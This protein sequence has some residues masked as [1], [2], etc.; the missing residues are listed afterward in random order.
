MAKQIIGGIIGF[1]LGSLGIPGFGPALGWSVGTLIGSSLDAPSMDVPKLKDLRLSGSSYGVGIPLV[2]GTARVGLNLVWVGEL[3]ERKDGAFKNGL[4]QKGAKDGFSIDLAGIVCQGLRGASVKRVKADDKVIWKPGGGDHNKIDPAITP[5]TEDQ[6][7]PAMLGDWGAIGGRGMTRH[8]GLV[9]IAIEDLDITET[10]RIP[11]LTVVVEGAPATVGDICADIFG[12]VGLDEED[13]DVSAATDAVTGFVVTQPA[14]ASEVLADLLEKYEYDLS[15][16]DGVL[17]LVKRG[18]S[19]V[20]TIDA[21]DL[22]ASAGIPGGDGRALLTSSRAKETDLPRRVALTYTSANPF[23]NYDQVTQT[24]VRLG[25]ASDN[26]VAL[27]TRLVLH[28]TEARQIAERFKNRAWIERWTF[29]F[30]LP[31]EYLFLA[32]ADCV[33]LPVGGSLRRV[34]ITRI[35]TGLIGEM[36]F[37]AVLDDAAVQAQGTP[38]SPPAAPTNPDLLPTLAT[39]FD[40]WSGVEIVPTDGLAPG[41][42]AVGAPQAGSAPWPGAEVFYSLDGGVSYVFAGRLASGGVFGETE[43]ALGDGAD[44]DDWDETNEVAVQL[45]DGVGAALEEASDEQVLARYTNIALLGEEVLGFTGALDNTGRSYTLSRLQRGL[46]GEPT[47]HASGD[48]FVLLSEGGWDRFSVPASL[49][50]QT[51]KVKVVTAGK[52]LAGVTAIDV[53]IPVP[54][55]P[56]ASPEEVQDVIDTLEGHRLSDPIDHVDGSAPLSLLAQDGAAD[57]QVLAWSESLGEWIAAHAPGR[58][59]T[60]FAQTAE[61]QIANTTS[62]L[63]LFG[64]GQGSREIPADTLEVGMVIRVVLKGVYATAANADAADLE[65]KLGSTV[66]ASAGAMDLESVA[67]GWGP[68]QPSWELQAELTV[69]AQ[70]ASGAVRT[71]GF[72]R[73]LDDFNTTIQ[74]IPVRSDPVT[75]DTT[76]DLIVDAVWDWA[77]ASTNYDIRSKTGYVELLGV[78]GVTAGVGG[79]GGDPGPTGPEGPAGAPGSQIYHDTGA[80]SG[81]LGI[82]GDYYLDTETNELYARESGLWSVIAELG[83]GGG[84]AGAKTALIEELGLTPGAPNSTVYVTHLP[85]SPLDGTTSVTWTFLRAGLFVESAPSGGAAGFEVYLNGVSILSA[86]LSIADGQHQATPATHF[87]VPEGHSGDVLAWRFNAIHGADGFNPTLYL[88]GDY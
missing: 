28:D 38:G 42:Y 52:P 1:G 47:G 57:G 82:D 43:D 66:V 48:R 19:V 30:S 11:N 44:L 50:G 76:T 5:G 2:W 60:I 41:F 7:I 67:G 86:P 15:E 22:G 32:P 63:T 12:M 84:G 27:S 85:Y 10:R 29:G 56:Y 39:L 23:L 83:G 80:P 14:K 18:G 79:G 81:G 45:V 34:R 54:S 71:D 88:Q 13:Y 69:T 78:T 3:T 25:A 87:A 35:T 9:L 6:A 37:E 75:V 46:R 26:D 73:F 4:F 51:I 58:G 70:G 68:T 20:A 31:I 16:I 40:A 49:I 77:T 33:L 59:G 64:T 21:E 61:K 65:I 17:T 72:L 8:P 53:E 62:A 36:R 55:S 74:S 24:A